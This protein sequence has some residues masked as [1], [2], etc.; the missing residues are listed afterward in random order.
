MNENGDWQT[1]LDYCDKL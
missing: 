1:V